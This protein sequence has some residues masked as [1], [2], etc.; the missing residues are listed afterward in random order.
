M[1]IGDTLI[2]AQ[3]STK[4]KEDFTKAIDELKDRFAKI[5]AKREQ[6]DHPAWAEAGTEYNGK[7]FKKEFHCAY[8]RYS[9]GCYD[10]TKQL[11]KG[12]PRQTQMDSLFHELEDTPPI[13]LIE[14]YIDEAE[15]WMG[16]QAMKAKEYAIEKL[17][18]CM[19]EIKDRAVSKM[20]ELFNM[21]DGMD[22]M[23]G[24]EVKELIDFLW[25]IIT[26][27][28]SIDTI[29]KLIE[30]LL[31][32]I[33]KTLWRTLQRLYEPYLQVIMLILWT[34]NVVVQ[35]LSL[36][37]ERIAKVMELIS[38]VMA[39]QIKWPVDNVKRCTMKISG[40]NP[41]AMAE[42]VLREA[43]TDMAYM[44]GQIS[45]LQLVQDK[46]SSCVKDAETS[47]QK[48][49]MLEKKQSEYTTKG[50]QYINSLVSSCTGQL[51]ACINSCLSKVPIKSVQACLSEMARITAMFA[52]IDK[53]IDKF[54]E[55]VGSLCCA[56]LDKIM[57]ALG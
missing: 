42:R 41:N 21:Q 16:E 17:Q 22:K 20:K 7:T 47:P 32:L 13:D 3:Q 2:K 33:L 27:K 44:N 14:D 43:Q 52:N 24:K 10:F 29:C 36:I 12:V 9:V 37:V 34:I 30:N 31:K 56:F 46:I 48:K 51:Q 50:Q 1:A 19:N 53:L 15:R 25:D 55:A 28:I 38:R 5:K 6:R 23:G 45:T 39:I 26:G 8:D 11:P 40:S 35:L 57:E 4:G 54:A 18:S 49:S